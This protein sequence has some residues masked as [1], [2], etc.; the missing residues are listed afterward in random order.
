MLTLQVLHVFLAAQLSLLPVVA[1][2]GGT[3]YAYL[4]GWCAANIWWNKVFKHL[5]GSLSLGSE[6]KDGVGNSD[7]EL[8]CSK[9]MSAAPFYAKPDAAE[10]DCRLDNISAL[11]RQALQL[12]T[13][14]AG[15]SHEQLLLLLT[16]RAVNH[17]Q[18]GG[19]GEVHDIADL[20][21]ATCSTEQERDGIN[22]EAAQ[23]ELLQSVAHA[24]WPLQ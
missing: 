10:Q 22:W 19:N 4:L 6:V 3:Y 23:E 5:V 15:L 13:A 1:A 9:G 11:K 7:R 18:P 24:V 20:L 21:G 14:N 12:L 16:C 17:M 2:H 8:Q